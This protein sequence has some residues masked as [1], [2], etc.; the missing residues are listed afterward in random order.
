MLLKHCIVLGV[1]F[2]SFICLYTLLIVRISWPDSQRKPCGR[3]GRLRKDIQVVS[4]RNVYRGAHWPPWRRPIFGFA[5]FLEIDYNAPHASPCFQHFNQN[6][7]LMRCVDQLIG[8]TPID[9]I[10]SFYLI[11][12]A[13]FFIK[14]HTCNIYY[15]MNSV[16]VMSY[17]F[18][19]YIRLPAVP[20]TIS[21]I[22]NGA[23]EHPCDLKLTFEKCPSK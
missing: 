19:L 3:L 22:S 23:W 14:P 8:E 11:H 17:Q 6:R 20:D 9:A 21:N 10:T 16:L 2:W 5:Y 12:L 1:V 15:I 13:T 18:F 4:C 7:D